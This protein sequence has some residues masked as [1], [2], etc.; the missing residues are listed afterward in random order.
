MRRGE[1][2]AANMARGS[3]EVEDGEYEDSGEEEVDAERDMIRENNA[4]Q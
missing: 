1:G 2:D 4:S 3:K